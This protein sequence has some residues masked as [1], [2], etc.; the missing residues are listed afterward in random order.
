MMLMGVSEQQGESLAVEKLRQ[1][2]LA[3]ER[4]FRNVIAKLGEAIAILDERGEVQY[5]NTAAECLFQCLEEELLG[6]EIFGTRVFEIPASLYDTETIQK[7][8]EPPDRSGTR[9]V[10]TQV[11]IIR[12][13]VET[14]IAEMRVVETQ[15][16]GRAAFVATFRDITERQKALNALRLR[17]AQLQEKTQQLQGALQELQDTQA[18]L[19]QTEKMSSLGQMVAGVAHEINN[20][21]NFIYGN[22]NHASQYMQDL[23]D[24]LQLY[25]KYYPN[26]VGDLEAE[27]EAIDLEF[28]KEDLPK[29]LSSMK[30]GTD[31]IRQIVLS[32]RNFSRLDEAD[33]KQVDIHEGIDSTLEILQ[34]RLK[35]KGG[36]ADIQIVKE[37]GE[38]S[39][40]ECYASQLNQVFMNVLANA[41]DAL[42]ESMVS[43]EWFPSGSAQEES[44]EANLSPDETPE[45]AAEPATI[46]VRTLCDREYLTVQISDNGPGMKEEVRQRIFDPFFTTKAVGK[47]TGLGLSISYQIVADKH[48]GQ[49]Q[50]YSV[51]GQGTEFVIEIPM[52]Q[53]KSQGRVVPFSSQQDW[54]QPHVSKRMPKRNETLLMG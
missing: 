52:K 10:Q 47:G 12:P 41:I 25:Q 1:E 34:S 22:I 36:A 16:E 5:V 20:P 23:L 14:A 44:D 3:S 42:E 37:Y 18:Q 6:K 46:R 26:P 4:R 21:V 33:I 15:W 27:M 53:K 13:E 51:P 24:L 29:L 9:V 8:G 45:I 2:L 39:E 40:V 43:G 35:G 31:R 48:G 11:E 54:P 38:L 17:E 19:I 30:L 49:L 28:L 50:C 32:L 7:M